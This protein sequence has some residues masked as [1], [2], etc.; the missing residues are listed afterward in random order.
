MK[1]IFSTASP[2]ARKVRVL[3]HEL[4]IGNHIE[5]APT[6]VSPVA[7]NELV[8][9]NNPL[10]KVPILITDAKEPIFDSRVICEYLI[11]N[12]GKRPVD[13]NSGAMWRQARTVAVADG[14]LDAALLIRYETTIRPA[15]LRWDDWIDGQ[16]RKIQGALHYLESVPQRINDVL[17]IDQIGVAC[18]LSY[19]D[20]RFA[21]IDWRAG[22]PNLEG[23]FGQVTERESMRLTA[24][25]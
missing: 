23:F 1:L 18:A 22:R 20:Y 6:A 17:S 21:E 10:A 25:E 5:M 15:Q 12:F 13:G 3:A 8:S 4:G 16:T 2:Y 7:G 19:L 11:H 24:P 9:A 14:L